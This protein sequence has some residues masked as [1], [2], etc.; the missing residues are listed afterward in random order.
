MRTSTTVEASGG[1]WRETVDF[2]VEAE[3]RGLVNTVDQ[4]LELQVYLPDEAVPELTG[5]DLAGEE[6]K[7]D[8]ERAEARG[9]GRRDR[10]HVH[11]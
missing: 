3:R 2:V 10:R 4:D 1:D 11:R 7:A 6:P 5:S 8:G 9:N